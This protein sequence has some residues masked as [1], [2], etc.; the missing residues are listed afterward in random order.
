MA[1]YQIDCVNKPDRMSPHDRITHV[2]G[3]NPT[4]IGR[5][6]EPTGNVVKFIENNTHRFYTRDDGRVAWVGVRTSAAG[7]KYL[8]THADGMWN[9]NLLAQSECG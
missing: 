8:Q 4:G 9:N 5:W 1:D 7:N 2:G 3:P 6:K